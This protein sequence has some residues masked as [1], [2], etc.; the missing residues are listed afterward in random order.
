MPICGLQRG[1]HVVNG[2]TASTALEQAQSWLHLLQQGQGA[3][4]ARCCQ[5]VDRQ[6]A[7]RSRLPDSLVDGQLHSAWRWEGSFHGPRSHKGRV[8]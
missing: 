6:H 1:L 7:A 5:S 3:R 2:N 4:D 8:L